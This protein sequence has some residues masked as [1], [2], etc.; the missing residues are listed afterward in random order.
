MKLVVIGVDPHHVVTEDQD[1]PK[2]K[3]GK[4]PRQDHYARELHLGFQVGDE[5]GYRIFLQRRPEKKVKLN[6]ATARP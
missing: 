5:V 6:G 3:Q 4:F 2:D 1:G